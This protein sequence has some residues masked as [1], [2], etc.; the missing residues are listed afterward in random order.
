[1]KG[2]TFFTVALVSALLVASICGSFI[3]GNDSDGD[4]R[5]TTFDED[6]AVDFQ[7]VVIVEDIGSL[8]LSDAES[9]SEAKAVVLDSDL[10]ASLEPDHIPK[11]NDLFNSGNAV[12]V[13]GDATPLNAMRVTSVFNPDAA[14]SVFIQRDGTMH[15]MS[16]SDGHTFEEDF[17]AWMDNVVDAEPS[18]AVPT[19]TYTESEQWNEGKLSVTN[20]YYYMGE[21]AG[22][23]YY[24]VQYG[25]QAQSIDL[26]WRIADMIAE[27]DVDG[28]NNFMNLVDSSP[29][30]TH[31][32]QEV[33]VSVSFSL[34]GIGSS[35]GW[36]FITPETLI[37]NECVNDEDIFRIWFDINED[38]AY[39][40]E[41]VKPGSMIKVSTASAFLASEVFS[42]QFEKQLDTFWPWSP[43]AEQKM[44]SFTTTAQLI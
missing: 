22:Y 16:S 41:S 43:S 10:L 8:D 30:S 3:N 44:F 4:S 25:M 12:I 6:S 42:V 1:M 27:C 9:V 38:T 32:M 15:C 7:N 36:T 40:V 2:I 29:S 19:A 24:A 26:D 11:I 39:D 34:S 18:G 23:K 33:S 17:D 13:R 35:V 14:F 21:S 5:T 28:L 31:V 20:S 37:H